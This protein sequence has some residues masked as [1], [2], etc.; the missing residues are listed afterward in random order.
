MK[1]EQYD[2]IKHTACFRFYEELNDFLLKE[3]HK[4][5]FLYKFTGNPSIK[6]TIEAIGVPHAEIDLILVD[7]RSVDFK[8]RLCSF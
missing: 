6:D 4:I 3:Q 5:A 1:D 7:G 8:Y 2:P